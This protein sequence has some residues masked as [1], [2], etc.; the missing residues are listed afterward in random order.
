MAN[1][2]EMPAAFDSLPAWMTWVDIIQEFGD[3]NCQ[4]GLCVAMRAWIQ[5]SAG[6]TEMQLSELECLASRLK[7]NRGE[8]SPDEWKELNHGLLRA[9]LAAGIKLRKLL[10]LRGWA[11]KNAS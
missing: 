2:S 10:S 4:C 5:E 9:A 8:T 3:P 11:N 7:A 1:D 6:R